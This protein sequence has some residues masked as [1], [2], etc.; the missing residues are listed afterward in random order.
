[1]AKFERHFTIVKTLH[2]Q[3]GQSHAKELA[4][5]RVIC[6]HA[7]VPAPQV[8]NLNFEHLR[9]LTALLPSE[10][11]D[12]LAAMKTEKDQEGQDVS[13]TYVP[14]RN[15]VMLS[16]AGGMA[17]ALRCHGIVGGWNAEDYSG[18]PDCRPR[19]L[20]A[21]QQALG[22][23]LRWPCNIYSPLNNA[24]KAHIIKLGKLIGAPLDLTWS[25]YAGGAEPCKTCPSC[26]VR[27]KGFEEAGIVD[28]ALAP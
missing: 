4:H 23:G 1:M 5:C 22:A 20:W 27:A 3:Y 21:M 10:G 11:F 7:G 14:G 2:F 18:Y 24:S 6:E 25:C 26:M 28:P 16:I 19:F 8:I 17:D 15:I 9:G 12:H 13:A